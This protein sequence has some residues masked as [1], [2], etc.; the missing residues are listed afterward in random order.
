MSPSSL[1]PTPLGHPILIYCP[2][3]GGPIPP[4][5]LPVQRTAALIRKP[6][7]PDTEPFPQEMT[8]EQRQAQTA[9]MPKGTESS[10]AEHGPSLG[11]FE[12]LE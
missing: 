3:C 12:E 10:E 5:A 6:R 8:P 2:H 1:E 4:V 9:I 11:D 7:I